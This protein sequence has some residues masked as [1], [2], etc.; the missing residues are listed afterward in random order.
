MDDEKKGDRKVFKHWESEK[1][2]R[3]SQCVSGRNEI[4]AE[5]D[6]EALADLVGILRTK[7]EVDWIDE[8]HGLRETN[9]KREDLGHDDTDGDADIEEEWDVEE[10]IKEDTGT[11][12]SEEADRA[13]RRRRMRQKGK[14]GAGL[15][16]SELS[17]VRK[18]SSLSFQTTVERWKERF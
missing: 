11:E 5:A 10:S 12:A 2:E 13:S 18:V 17:D 6:P 14:S 15:S 16:P 4:L 9:I 7:Y 3:I 1:K 8:A